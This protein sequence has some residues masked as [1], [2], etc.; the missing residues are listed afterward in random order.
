MTTRGHPHLLLPIDDSQPTERAIDFVAREVPDAEV[1]LLHVAGIP[2][3]LIEHPGAEDPKREAHLEAKKSFEM[4][5][6]EKEEKKLDPETIF[7][8]AEERLARAGLRVHRKLLTEAH[9]DPART[10]I[11]EARDGHYD[12]VVLGH[13][14]HGKV[15][16]WLL[17]S[18]AEDVTDELGNERVTVVD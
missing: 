15:G 16:A 14:H 4:Q 8:S 13:H 5:R 17:P 3:R 10:I 11:D 9:P 1:T 18:V 12:R 2:P 6:Y 7:R